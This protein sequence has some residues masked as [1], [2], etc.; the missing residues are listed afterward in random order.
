VNL[1]VRE[2][3]AEDAAAAW[4]LGSL[5]F[6]YYD[7]PMPEGWGHDRP[8]FRQWGAFDE[9]GRLL[10]KAV[11]REQGHWF[12]GRVVPAS[13]VASVAVA[14]EMRGKGIARAVLTQ[15]LAGAR[16]RGAVI[17]TLFDT[18]PMPYRR[19]GWEEV[20]ARSH[21][22]VPTVLLV[23][24][25]TA[26]EVRRAT[27]Q[28]VPRIEEIYR[29]VARA[30]TG[31]TD[32]AGPVMGRSP[33][34]FLEAW[35]GVTVVAEGD[36][37]LGYMTWDRGEGYQ[38]SARLH[39]GDLI[40]LTPAA[41]GA[42]LGV[43]GGWASVAPTTVLWL[44]DHDPVRWHTAI[45]G[46]ARVEKREPWM[47]RLVDAQGAVAARGFNP[48]VRGSAGLTIEDE[49]CPWN[50]GHWR[51]VLDGGDG[52]LEPGGDGGARIT[53]RGL[54]LWYAGAAT[55]SQLRRLGLLTGNPD[56]DALLEVATAG[57]PPTLL[58]YF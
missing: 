57:P 32:R 24:P 19:L 45:A 41:T 48:Y 4:Q 43:L 50:A 47:L 25:R 3:T 15:L 44:G 58:D 30:A 54:A 42:L 40:G 56:G 31:M 8:G 55:P 29:E 14:A 33:A 35:N 20:G 53:P 28:D 37:L 10:G 9:S 17:S 27:V 21:I 16:D 22:A 26:L 7:R 13:A 11:D 51:F 38:A 49:Q 18:T 5:T 46:A 2:T 6:G 39:V 1:T 23:Q 36:R 34:A 12:G 52:R